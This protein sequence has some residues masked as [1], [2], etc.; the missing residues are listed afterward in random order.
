[1]PKFLGKPAIGIFLSTFFL[2]FS[3]SAAAFA[4]IAVILSLTGQVEYRTDKKAEWQ[5]AS[6]GTQIPDGGSISTGVDSRAALFFQGA[7][8]STPR[9]VAIS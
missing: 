5:P 8:C 4:E 6:K 2:I 1:M 7:S 3:H 9:A